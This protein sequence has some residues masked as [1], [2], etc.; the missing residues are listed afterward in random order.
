M[1]GEESCLPLLTK[2]GQQ[3]AKKCGQ[4]PLSVALVAGILVEMEKKVECR[5]KLANNLGPHIHKDSRAVIE[6]SYQILP[7]CLRPCFLYFGTLLEDSVISVPKLTQLWISE[8]FV[9]SCEGKSLEDIAEGYLGNLMGRNLVKGTK[10][11]SR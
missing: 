6:Q 3:L 11:N 10:R 4:L 8:G 7:Y 9:K 5:E 1:F 2:I